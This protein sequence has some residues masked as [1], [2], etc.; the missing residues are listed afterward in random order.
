MPALG[1]RNGRAFRL[2][3][4]GFLFMTRLFSS[5]RRRQ[6]RNARR[7]ARAPRW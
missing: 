3:L 5:R 7:I 1:D 2:L 4:S 6:I